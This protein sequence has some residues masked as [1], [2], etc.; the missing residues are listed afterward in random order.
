MEVSRKRIFLKHLQPA[1]PLRRCIHIN[2]EPIRSADICEQALME[3][4]DQERNVVEE[5]Q[6]VFDLYKDKEEKITY[7]RDFLISLACCPMSKRKP[8][9]LPDLPII[10]P[11][12]QGHGL[13]Y[14]R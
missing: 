7:T 4:E 2:S 12:A 9:K 6:E 10:L 14:M 1:R 5:L 13:P 11:K 3:V 8:E